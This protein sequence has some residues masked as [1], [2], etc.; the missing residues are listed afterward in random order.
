[1]SFGFQRNLSHKRP[2]IASIIPVIINPML[3]QRQKSRLLSDIA[4]SGKHCFRFWVVESIISASGI[5]KTRELK[6]NA[7][8]P[9]ITKNI[10]KDI[11]ANVSFFI[12]YYLLFVV[13]KLLME[14][15]A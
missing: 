2:S 1:M 15:F 10:A 13:L 11:H 3:L 5:A 6:V 8:P 7:N 4:P 14:V 9:K 12:F